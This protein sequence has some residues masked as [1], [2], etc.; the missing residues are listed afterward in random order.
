M[1]DFIKAIL[2]LAISCLPTI[3]VF[4]IEPIHEGADPSVYGYWA[5]I[6]IQ[7]FLF[8]AGISFYYASLKIVNSF[9]K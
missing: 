6:Y 1:K 4:F 7:G 8:L 3:P 9:I 2:A 5:N